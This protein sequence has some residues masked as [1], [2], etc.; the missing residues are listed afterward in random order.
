MYVD[1]VLPG[2]NAEEVGLVPGALIVSIN[3]NPV[4]QYEATFRSGSE[5]SNILVGRR[6]GDEVAL[7]V[8]DPD[9]T[10]QKK[11]IVTRRTRMQVRW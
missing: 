8:V 6:E 2:S 1:Q 9:E 11:I 7:V 5:L 4:A 3:G 10:R